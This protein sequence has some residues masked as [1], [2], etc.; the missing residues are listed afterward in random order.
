[1]RV[2]AIASTQDADTRP[3][4]GVPPAQVRANRLRAYLV[5]ADLIAATAGVGLFVGLVAL[6]DSEAIGTGEAVVVSLFSAVC[7]LVSMGA[8]RLYRARVCSVRAVEM[9]RLIRATAVGT[10]VAVVAGN[11][12]DLSTPIA[13]AL[14]LG[15][16][17]FGT[18]ALGRSVYAAWL[19]HQRTL[20]R[21]VRSI[22]LV[23]TNDEARSLHKLITEHPEL[24]FTVA[25]AVG[26]YASGFPVPIIG[27]ASDAAA[28]IVE[29]AATGAIV[30]V[31]SFDHRELNGVLRGLARNRIHTQTSSGFFG[32]SPR[33]IRATPLAYEP[34]S[35]IEPP[36]LNPWQQWVKRGID[37]VAAS[38][39]LVLSLPILLAAAA[40]LKFLEGG[41]V[42][43][44]Q[45]RVGHRGRAFTVYKFRTMVS[46]AEA[47][48]SEVAH[49]NERQGPLFKLTA[50][51]RRTRVGT[52]LEATSIDE[53]PQLINVLR[54]DMSVVGPRPALPDEIATYDDE[55]LTRLDV[56]PGITGLWQAEARDNESFDVYRRLDLFYVEN[57]SLS[58]DLAIILGTVRAVLTRLVHLGSRISPPN[59]ELA[60]LHTG[61]P[62]DEPRLRLTTQSVGS[63]STTSGELTL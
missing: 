24:G 57:W 55:L 46:D 52:I 16:F 19:R 18:I 34:L 41:P 27:P 54:G 6:V 7:I 15:A 9:S 50:D 28:I 36:T 8:V 62:A 25:A 12:I 1:M 40:A 29:T 38:V 3:D 31:T 35:Y 44:R 26:P 60:R 43:F 13:W 20:G 58:L 32:I 45:Q 11:V 39:A 21:Y 61:D 49:L 17:E 59:A 42:I 30:A 5:A 47:R 51:P 56:R 63:H 14:V 2:D 37:V 10:T 23:G 48:L 4:D 53:L 33:R 22:V